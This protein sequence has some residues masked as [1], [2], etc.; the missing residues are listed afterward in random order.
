MP[1]TTEY[2]LSHKELATALVKALDLHEGIWGLHF[3]F[4]LGGA[5]VNVSQ[6]EISPTALVPV[7]G[8]GIR[9]FDEENSISV[10]AA[11]VN[12]AAS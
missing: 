4:G 11:K 1:E 5:N 7:L 2:L 9:K 10:D 8:V 12:P 6:T 3:K